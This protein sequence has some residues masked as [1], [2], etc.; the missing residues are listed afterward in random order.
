[1]KQIKD[2]S[3]VFKKGQKLKIGINT[4][5]GGPWE[6]YFEKVFCLTDDKKKLISCPIKGKNIVKLSGGMPL[7][8]LSCTD[9]YLKG[10]EI[11]IGNNFEIFGKI[12]I[13]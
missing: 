13:L 7:I 1:M 9:I 2:L 12:E 3:D 4:E 10:K 11:L 5:Y 8:D 6:Y